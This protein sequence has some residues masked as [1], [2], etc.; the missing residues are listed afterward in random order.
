MFRVEHKVS[1]LGPYQHDWEPPSYVK[2]ILMSHTSPY[3][4]CLLSRNLY[5][6]GIKNIWKELS[7]G[8][9]LFAFNSLGDFFD[10]GIPWDVFKNAGFRMIKIDKSKVIYYEGNSQ[11]VF[12]PVYDD[13]VEFELFGPNHTELMLRCYG[14]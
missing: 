2:D 3:D 8:D 1:R 7:G 10:K 11:S 14:H 6:A 13:Y 5:D 4:D 12:F 9:Y